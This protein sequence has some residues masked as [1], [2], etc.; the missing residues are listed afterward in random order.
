MTDR[1]MAGHV[2]IAGLVDQVIDRAMVN[3]QLDVRFGD[4]FSVTITVPRLDRVLD[5]SDHREP[6]QFLEDW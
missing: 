4:Q 5:P 1:S 2:S 3:Q 6:S